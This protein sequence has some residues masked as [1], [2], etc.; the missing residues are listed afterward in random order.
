[1]SDAI[2]EL[3]AFITREGGRVPL[4]VRIAAPVQVRGGDDYA[5]RVHG[6]TVFGDDKYI[7]GV[8]AGQAA[9]L[10]VQFVRSLLAGKNITDANGRPVAW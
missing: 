2:L 4:Y 9:T 3:N 7:H 1:M 8:D 5:C 10:A 6:P